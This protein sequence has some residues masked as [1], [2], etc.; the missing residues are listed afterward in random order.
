MRNWLAG[1]FLSALV[2]VAPACAAD[3]VFEKTVPLATTGILHLENLNGS[4]QVRG[5]D[6]NEVEIRAVKTARQSA[7]DLNAVVIDVN[8]TAGRVNIATRYPQD[9]SVDV[10]VEY[11]VRVPY[12]ALLERVA[13]VNGNVGVTGMDTSGDL[14]TVNGNIEAYNCAGSLSAHTTNGSIHEEIVQ[15]GEE[16]MTL[17]TVNGS[18]TL[19]LPSNAGADLD[20]LSMNGGMMTSE[21]PFAIKSSLKRGALTGKI[22]HGGPLLRMRAVNGSVGVEALK[23]T[24]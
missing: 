1:A 20:V 15:L 21:I 9:R 14:R 24:A 16:G 23:P 18:V 5:W 2:C 3:Q 19:G 7:A 4:V 10:S 13:T 8:A 6:R 11:Q 22:G 12:R 17:E